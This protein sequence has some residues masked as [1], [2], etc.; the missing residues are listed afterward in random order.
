VNGTFQPKKA[1]LGILL[2]FPEIMQ[3]R[4]DQATF[5]IPILGALIR[6]LED[7]DAFLTEELGDLAPASFGG[8]RYDNDFVASSD[9]KGLFGFGT[10][11]CRQLR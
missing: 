2:A 5:F 3:N 9:M 7:H 1:S 6:A 10:H 8:A 11:G 4:L